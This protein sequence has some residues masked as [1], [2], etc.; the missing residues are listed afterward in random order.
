MLNQCDLR[1][2]GRLYVS[3]LRPLIAAILVL[4]SLGSATED[5]TDGKSRW[6]SKLDTLRSDWVQAGEGKSWKTFRKKGELFVAWRSAESGRMARDKMPKGLRALRSSEEFGLVGFDEDQVR[7]DQ[8]ATALKRAG[9]VYA[10]PNLVFESARLRGMALSDK[11][12]ERWMRSRPGRIKVHRK[13]VLRIGIFDTGIDQD[14]PA[15]EGWLGSGYDAFNQVSIPLR[16]D[17]SPADSLTADENGHGTMVAGVIAGTIGAYAD[18]AADVTLHPIKVLDVQGYG[19]LETVYRGLKWAI[20]NRM[21]ISNFSF[22]GYEQSPLLAKLFASAQK[23]GMFCVAAAGNDF[24]SEA[25]YPAAYDGVTGVGSA[26]GQGRVSGFSNWGPSVDI[27][28]PGESWNAPRSDGLAKDWTA[29]AGTSAASA[30]VTGMVG[31]AYLHDL[32]GKQVRDLLA[33]SCLPFRH[34]SHP[35]ASSIPLLMESVLEQHLFG[36]PSSLPVFSEVSIRREKELLS[37]QANLVNKGLKASTADTLFAVAV[38]DETRR[39]CPL[40]EIP[41]LAPG[42]ARPIVGTLDTAACLPEDFVRSQDWKSLPISLSLGREERVSSSPIEVIF[43]PSPL[44]RTRIISA[45]ITPQRF[46]EVRTDRRIL[47]K[48]KNEGT[49]PSDSLAISAFFW[50]GIHEA[51]WNSDTTIAGPTVSVPRI[52]PDQVVEVEIPAP[53]MD[54]LPMQFTLNLDIAGKLEAFTYL[55]SHTVSPAGHFQANYA[56]ELHRDIVRKAKD[57]L[58]ALGLRLPD[59]D[60]NSSVDYLGRTAN[61]R[62][63]GLLPGTS[64]GTT[65]WTDAYL[66]EVG[67]TPTAVHGAHDCDG[68][69]VIYGYTYE[70]TWDTHFWIVDFGDDNGMNSNGTNHHSALSKLRVLLNGG[71]GRSQIPMNGAIWHYQNGYKKGAWYLLGHALHLIG[72]LSIG[73]HVNDEHAH[74]TPGIGDVYHDWMDKGNYTSFNNI[75]TQILNKGLGLVDP[76]HSLAQGDAVRFLAYTTAQVG[77]SF[78]RHATGQAAAY[79]RYAGNRT[80]AGDD[81]HYDSYMNGIFASLPSRPLGV[82]HLGKNE[83]WDS[84]PNACCWCARE[85]QFV[86]QFGASETSADCNGDGHKDIDNTDIVNGMPINDDGDITRIAQNSYPYAIRAAAGLIYYFAFESGQYGYTSVVPISNI[87]Y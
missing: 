59:L 75:T 57:L 63:W 72:D 47:V 62:D 7:L 85:C 67:V 31:L 32:E 77:N 26:D 34:E 80:A 39:F 49:G 68:V 55:Q 81:P 4:T 82:T 76:Y 58:D 16:D 87:L 8:A 25:A 30:Y 41:P 21:D 54:S 6:R 45:W 64:F 15:L 52:D 60:I 37:V 1:I 83:V 9:A 14:N 12:P 44:P 19:T 48:L 11:N 84:C 73:S 70:D 2:P 69:D 43:P 71:V 23:T 33:A 74:G 22:S 35:G 18:S 13:Q 17:A 46:A 42:A 65:T 28:A 3:F 20:K 79:D 51:V 50:H 53:G 24:T 66:A 29:F 5:A 61:Y 10:E 40:A 56:Q 78:P 86:D 36:Q 38:W 27:F